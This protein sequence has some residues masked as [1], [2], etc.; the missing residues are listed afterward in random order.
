[1]GMPFY[2]CEHY[3]AIGNLCIRGNI[4]LCVLLIPTKWYRLTILMYKLGYPS[5]KVS[6][7]KL[8]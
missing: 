5:F 6:C 8:M 3:P 7:L 1:M 4:L 2:N